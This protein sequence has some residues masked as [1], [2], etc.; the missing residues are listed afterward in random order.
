MMLIIFIELVS[1]YLFINIIGNIMV[2]M[3]VL[4]YI[5]IN[6]IDG[7]YLLVVLLI[8]PIII[9][10]YIMMNSL[11]SR[12]KI[13]LLIKFMYV[14]LIGVIIRGLILVYLLTLIISGITMLYVLGGYIR[15]WFACSRILVISLMYYFLVEIKIIWLRV[16]PVVIFFIKQNIMIV[17]FMIK[18]LWFY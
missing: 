10:L 2:V 8:W 9:Y 12:I 1:F 11:L 18:V 5:A 13:G 4:R 14:K 7:L 15:Y 17:L 6:Y 16:L 3:V